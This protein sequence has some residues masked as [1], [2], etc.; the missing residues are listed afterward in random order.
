M[1][2]PEHDVLRRRLL[3]AGLGAGAVA[4]VEPQLV[5]AARVARPA[6][7]QR[8]VRYA[9]VDRLADLVIPATDTPGASA[10][11]AA[12]FVLLALDRRV[13]DLVPAMY[14]RLRAALNAAARGDFFSLPRAQQG[15]VLVAVDRA[16]HTGEAQSGSAEHAWK[17]IKA[18]ILVG[19]YTSEIGASQEL[20]YDPVPGGTTYVQVT[21][22]F[23][24][25]VYDGMGGAL[26][27]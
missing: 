16:A 1:T 17:R 12:A 5:A 13:S 15:T 23:R 7:Q 21:P 11:G 2:N 8:D 3:L 14:E 10:A 9:P 19:Y 22:D 20:V 25:S 18:A 26:G 4:L 27:G 24:S 6:L